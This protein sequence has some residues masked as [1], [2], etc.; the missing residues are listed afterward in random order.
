MGDSAP[1]SLLWQM[2]ALL[3]KGGV[4]S[5]ADLARRL[6]VSEGLVLVMAEDM[7]RRGYLARVDAGCGGGCGGCQV[8]F[9]CARPPA[10]TMPRSAS[11]AVLILTPKGRHAGSA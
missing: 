10:G 4:A 5:T 11:G 3:G 2:L 9:S 8:A 7:T 1:Y 6:G